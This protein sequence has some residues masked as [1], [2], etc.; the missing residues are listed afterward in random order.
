[1]PLTYQCH[2]AH[3]KGE[4]VSLRMWSGRESELWM[5]YVCFIRLGKAGF[6]KAPKEDEGSR[7]EQGAEFNLPIVGYA[8]SFSQRTYVAEAALLLPL[9]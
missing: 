8:H 7:R 3:F 2:H 1:M 9:K 4:H 6:N 5:Y